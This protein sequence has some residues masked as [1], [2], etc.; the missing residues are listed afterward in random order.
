MMTKPTKH[1]SGD[2]GSY[3]LFDST[4]DVSEV[5]PARTV[6]QQTTS[7]DVDQMQQQLLVVNNTLAA[8]RWYTKAT[9]ASAG[10]VHL[11]REHADIPAIIGKDGKPILLYRF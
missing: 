9:E 1:E 6:I 5:S 11:L 4:T 10:V 7:D 2:P 8:L 3:Y